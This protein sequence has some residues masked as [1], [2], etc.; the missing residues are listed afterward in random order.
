MAVHVEREPGKSRVSRIAIDIRL[1]LG[2]PDEHRE[3]VV[4]AA[5][6]CAVK[7][8]LLDPPAF[9]IRTV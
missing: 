8:H 3:A 4:R 5:D 2:F 1:P 7:K 9:E 6:L